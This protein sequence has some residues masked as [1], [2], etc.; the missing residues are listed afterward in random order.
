[1]DRQLLGKSILFTVLIFVAM[2]FVCLLIMVLL[3]YLPDP[4]ALLD[5]DKAMNMGSFFGAVGK[6]PNGF[7]ASLFT[8][9]GS[10]VLGNFFALLANLSSGREM[11]VD[12]YGIGTTDLL[13][14]EKLQGIT[15]GLGL[16]FII[17]TFL[18]PAL[19]VR[20]K[21]SQDEPKTAYIGYIIG[22]VVC[23]LVPLIMG[24]AKFIFPMELNHP[25]YVYTSLF[26]STS[27]YAA[28]DYMNYFIPWLMSL[29]LNLPPPRFE[30]SWDA[31]A[32]LNV[33]LNGAFSGVIFGG[34][35]YLFGT[36]E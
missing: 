13:R 10:S 27:Y 21:V 11:F 2:N 4:D 32:V 9:A 16:A 18:V 34:L 23:A 1:M 33:L 29:G 3:G 28:G 19:I 36:G 7:I 15:Y 24:A 26:V 8:P 6:D 30:P 12:I 35:G 22:I 31:F 5:T 14:T 17:A 25:D 20:Y